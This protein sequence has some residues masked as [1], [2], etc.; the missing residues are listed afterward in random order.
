MFLA[1]APPLSFILTRNG[2]FWIWGSA[3][4][5]LPTPTTE[6]IFAPMEADPLFCFLGMSMDVGLI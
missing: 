3:F 6:I 1:K 2:V 5:T 4:H